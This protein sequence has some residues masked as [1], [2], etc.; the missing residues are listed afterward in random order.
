[1]TDAEAVPDLLEQVDNPVEA[2]EADGA[3]DQQVVYDALERRGARAVIPPR[4]DAEDPS[5]WQHG[6]SPAR[7]G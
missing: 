6:G 3:Y 2:A 7:P 4:R 1:M 5:A